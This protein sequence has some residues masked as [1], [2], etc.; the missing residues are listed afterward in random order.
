MK[1]D[2]SSPRDATVLEVFQW[3]EWPLANNRWAELADS[4]AHCSFFLTPVWVETWLAVFGQSVDAAILIFEN[5]GW[6]VGACLVTNAKNGRHWDPVTGVALNTTGELSADTTYTE[7]NDILC[8]EGFEGSVTQKL[9]EYLNQR[10]WDELQLNGFIPGVGYRGLKSV[11][12]PHCECREDVQPSY[13]VDLA[14][15]QE[16]GLPYEKMLSPKCRK[17]L[18][19]NIRHHSAQGEL[20]LEWA[21]TIA[22]GLAFLNE[23][24]E[25]SQHRWTSQ[26]RRGIFS[27]ATFLSFH[28]QLI[29][30][31][32][33]LGST[34]LA[35]LRAGP[36]TI[37]IVYNLVHREIV[38]FYQC[39]YGYG[40]DKRLS[41]GIVTL[42]A[43]IQYY[44]DH[45]YKQY[46]FMGGADQYKASLAT[47]CRNLVWATIRRPSLKLLARDQLRHVKR[48]IVNKLKRSSHAKP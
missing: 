33:E 43:V 27:S 35:R 25:L 37:G 45:G 2:T 10:R 5:A 39:G 36:H 42:A 15:V 20:I 11:A 3:H 31:S 16:S 17:H 8:R 1:T 41:P 12:A 21:S 28:K 19:Q 9:F 47:G 23:L 14:A 48:T 6:P 44:A 13:Y 38:Y 46:E 4:V 40:A 29:T 22:E 32:F 26:R 24:A 7:F 30:K 34:Q 18:R